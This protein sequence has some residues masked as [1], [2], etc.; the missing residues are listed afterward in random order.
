MESSAVTEWY[1]GELGERKVVSVT[2][3]KKCT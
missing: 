2:W 3:P 1:E